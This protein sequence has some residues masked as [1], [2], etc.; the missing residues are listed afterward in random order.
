MNQR[1]DEKR[2]IVEANGNGHADPASLLSGPLSRASL[3][4]RAAIGGAGA[5]SLPA[6]LA[7]CG[8]GGEEAAQTTTGTQTQ[9]GGQKSNLTFYSVTHG[10][11]GNVF[12]AIY[13]NG[14]RDGQQVFGVSVKDLPL[15]QFS[16]AGYVDLLNQAIAAK[17]D[18]IFCTIVEENAVDG[19][20]RQAITSGI[21][22]I[23]VN[24]PDT[25]PLGQRI[26]YLFYVG[27]DEEAGGRLTA[28]R[29]LAENSSLKHAVCIIHEPGHTGL[30][31]RCRGYG[32]ELVKAGTKV[33]KLPSTKDA[34]QATEQIKGFLQTNSDIDAIFGVGPQPATFALQ[35][36]DELGKKGQILVSAYDMTEDLLKEIDAGNLVST[37]DQQQYLQSFEPINWLKLHVEHG[38]VLAPGVDML[39]G[40]ALVDKTNSAK[41]AEGVKEGFR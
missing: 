30:E 34:T 16:V 13:R 9:Q 21:P 33:T 6:L 38:F 22:V 3:L 1:D 20:L 32:A 23:A 28:Q 11:S 24:V 18:G 37:I 15:E 35:A 27:G 5:A 19:P 12:W 17:P 36:L 7:A 2:P 39:T 31:A 26:P 10:E 8:G 14:I 4:K 25:R 41:V 40:P 29:Q